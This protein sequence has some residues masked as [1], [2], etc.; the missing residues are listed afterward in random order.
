MSPD[1]SG[2]GFQAL[3]LFSVWVVT[4][5]GMAAAFTAEHNSGGAARCAQIARDPTLRSSNV[6]A[7]VSTAYIDFNLLLTL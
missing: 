2:S 6:I 5:I 3:S 7:N 1:L 4:H